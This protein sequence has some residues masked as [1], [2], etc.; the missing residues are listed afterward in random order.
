MDGK[1]ESYYQS[2]LVREVTLEGMPEVKLTRINNCE[3]L[4]TPGPGWAPFKISWQASGIVIES[5]LR[6]E[7]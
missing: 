1:H 7:L 4:V 3:V 2:G 5:T 6:W